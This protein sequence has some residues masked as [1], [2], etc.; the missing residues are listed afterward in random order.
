ME[1]S[2]QT[3]ITAAY[4]SLKTAIDGRTQTSTDLANQY[5]AMGSL[6][7]AAD[8]ADAAELFY[9]HA[10]AISPG[11]MRWPYYLG[12]VYMAKTEPAKAVAAFERALRIQPNDVATLVWLGT[13]QLDQGRADLAEPRFSQALQAQP[14]GVAAL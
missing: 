13:V 10:E 5:G 3:Q 4:S 7:L 8:Y 14:H 12:H 9:Q 6:L 2:V 1:P 11:D